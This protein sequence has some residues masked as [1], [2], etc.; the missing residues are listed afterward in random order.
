MLF[1]RFTK[2]LPIL[3]L[4]IFYASFAFAAV[5]HQANPPQNVDTPSLWSLPTIGSPVPALIDFT[6]ENF[7][8]LHVNLR[9]ETS[10]EE[11]PLL[12]SFPDSTADF[13][14]KYFGERSI[15]T[16][17]DD[18]EI[19][20]SLVPLSD[21]LTMKPLTYITNVELLLQFKY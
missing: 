3:F 15:F 18:K 21:K 10:S 6:N 19:K 11:R 7:E 2:P 1:K 4:C 8:G 14:A 20:W 9:S 12:A 16:F 17:Y 13:A 5:D